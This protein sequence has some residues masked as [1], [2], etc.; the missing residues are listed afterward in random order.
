VD[1]PYAPV[2]IAQHWERLETRGGQQVSEV[3][4][5]GPVPTG[6]VKTWAEDVRLAHEGSWVAAG[7]PT[8]TERLAALTRLF[9]A[10][11]EASTR[12]ACP[13]EAARRLVWEAVRS[14]RS[15]LAARVLK[16]VRV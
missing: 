3:R 9:Q 4:Q 12:Y 1:R 6:G 14:Y 13:R 16:G 7:L 15:A 5:Y 11:G 10:L 2:L 8:S